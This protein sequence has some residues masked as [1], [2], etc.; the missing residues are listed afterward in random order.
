MQ[1]KGQELMDM[2]GLQVQAQDRTDPTVAS[3]LKVLNEENTHLI[4]TYNQLEDRLGPVT[5]PHSPEKPI[6]PAEEA[7]G[8]QAEHVQRI[9]EQI[10]I[11]RN[12]RYRIQD[13]LHYLQ[14]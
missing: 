8:G 3:L 9:Q 7:A 10:T 2:Q 6:N 13:Q 1:E 12:F 14:V 4:E 11:M 5:Q